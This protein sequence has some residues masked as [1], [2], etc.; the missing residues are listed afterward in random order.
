MSLLR[1][2][3]NLFG[4]SSNFDRAIYVLVVLLVAMAI[5]GPMFA[6]HTIYVS[7]IRNALQEPSAEHWFGTDDQG[8]DVFWR[9]IAGSRATLLSATLIVAL[10]SIIGVI[11]ATLATI[12]PRWLDEF[13]MRT[14]DIGLALPGLVVALGFAA[15][16]G[17]S[18]TSAIVAKAV[19]G[20][21]VTARLLRGIMQ[22]T[23]TSQF[24]VGA[25]AMGVS[26]WRLMTRHVL[27]NSLDILI[28][29]WAGDIGSA[30]LVLAGMSFIGVGAQ[31]PSAEW[32]AM[33]AVAKGHVA[34]AWWAV[35]APGVAIALTAIGFGLLGDILQVRRDPSLRGKA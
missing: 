2:I 22:Q 25:Q 32:G 31:P 34:T 33:I 18:L 12:G 23:M 5:F 4:S 7:D 13:L 27:P 19:T 9:V 16:M 15:A 8:R 17:P 24:V 35:T 29:R 26:R 28:V 21:P 1:A 20:W 11:V 30:V 3:R 14:T 10:Y 6:P